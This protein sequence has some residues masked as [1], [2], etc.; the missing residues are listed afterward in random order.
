MRNVKVRKLVLTAVLAAVSSVLMMFSF[1]V[2]LMPP[3]IKMDFSELP[4][5]IA[6]FSLGPVSGVAVCLVKNLVN[7]TMTTTGGVGELSNF[8][9]GATLTLVAGLLYRLKP[10]RRW[11][12]LV[13]GMVGAAAMAGVSML[14]NYYITYPIY[15]AFMPMEAIIGAYQAILP[16][17]DNLWQALAIFNLPFTF[18]KGMV[19][20]VIAVVVALPIMRAVE[21]GGNV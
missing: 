15:T 18:I 16:W 7:L 14:T 11:M 8:L 19:S 20:V 3:F 13:A 17:V 2:P 5:V 1:S 4:A 10:G 6:A 12:V 9:L 21:K